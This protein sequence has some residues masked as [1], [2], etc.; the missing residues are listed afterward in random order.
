MVKSGQLAEATEVMS[1]LLEDPEIRQGP[2]MH[3]VKSLEKALGLAMATIEQASESI[4]GKATF[5]LQKSDPATLPPCPVAVPGRFQ[6]MDHCSYEGYYD[7][8]MTV[9][10]E[11]F[12][13]DPNR[14]DRMR[15]HSLDFTYLFDKSLSN[16]DHVLMGR[17]RQIRTAGYSTS[18]WK[19][20]FGSQEARVPIDQCPVLRRALSGD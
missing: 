20:R 7:T 2:D 16:P 12:V 11:Y 10:S 8:D 5:L 4:S 15:V 1:E 9:P 6:S 18:R 13:E 14:P 19:K 17:G 3:V